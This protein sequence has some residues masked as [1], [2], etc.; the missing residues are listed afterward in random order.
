MGCESRDWSDV[1]NAALSQHTD[2]IEVILEFGS[3]SDYEVVMSKDWNKAMEKVNVD[4][5]GSE[6]H[7]A[8]LMTWE[9]IEAALP[10]LGRAA[11]IPV[12][13][14]ADGDMYH[15]L[16]DPS[17]VSKPENGWEEPPTNDP[18]IRTETREESLRIIRGCTQHEIFAL[19]EKEDVVKVGGWPLGAWSLRSRKKY[20]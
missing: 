12:E 6:V 3:M 11:S 17:M 9:R 14:L 2:Y 19:I 20:G 7:L 1:Q 15:V 5:A 13:R 18:T 4:F 10:P 8:Q 16:R